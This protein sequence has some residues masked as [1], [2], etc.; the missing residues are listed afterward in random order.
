[1]GIKSGGG[2][3][4]QFPTVPPLLSLSWN[5]TLDPV[6]LFPPSASHPD[7]V[8]ASVSLNGQKNVHLFVQFIL[9]ALGIA[10]VLKPTYDNP[11]LSTSVKSLQVHLLLT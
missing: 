7:N 10:Q 6:G 2:H 4:S 11:V 5:K 8:Y 1:M 3:R 9:C